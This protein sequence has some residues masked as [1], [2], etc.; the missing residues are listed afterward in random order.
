[1]TFVICAR[2][3]NSVIAS[4]SAITMEKQQVVVRI[5]PTCIRINTLYVHRLS[6]AK[7]QSAF[8][9]TTLLFS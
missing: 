6:I 4:L 5:A 9:A 7:V 1:M 2:E 8:D 3:T